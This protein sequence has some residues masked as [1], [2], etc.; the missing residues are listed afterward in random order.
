MSVFKEDSEVW[1]ESAECSKSG[2]EGKAIGLLTVL[3]RV[4][5]MAA[6]RSWTGIQKWFFAKLRKAMHREGLWG[7]K[8]HGLHFWSH[9]PPF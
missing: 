4:G 2:G 6:E 5:H 9:G 8:L 3:T 7:L 1:S